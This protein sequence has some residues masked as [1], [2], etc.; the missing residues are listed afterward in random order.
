MMTGAEYAAMAEYAARRHEELVATFPRDT[1]IVFV[2]S[3]EVY[4]AMM[5]YDRQFLRMTMTAGGHTTYHDVPICVINEETNDFFMPVIYSCDLRHHEG[6]QVDDFV[7]FNDED[8]D[9]LYRLVRLERGAVYADT[10][11]TV[12]F[13]D[14]TMPTMAHTEAATADATVADTVV[15]AVTNTGRTAETVTVNGGTIGI[16]TADAARTITINTDEIGRMVQEWA[17][18]PVT[19]ADW[20]PQYVYYPYESAFGNIAYSWNRT[21]E[22]VKESEL[23]PG[24]TKLIDEYLSSF[25]ISGA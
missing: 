9:L 10:G 2:V 13:L 4:L 5:C 1:N 18:A 21:Q 14:A 24:D 19:V 17:T 7:L 11:L 22:P 3:Q 23:N 25:L 6:V 12:T 20:A 8:D 15:N 16:D